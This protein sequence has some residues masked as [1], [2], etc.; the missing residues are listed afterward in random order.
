[1]QQVTIKNEFIS[2]S[3]L[4]YGAII[5]KILFKDREGN[6]LNLAVGF[7]NPENY[8][9]DQISLGACVGRFAGRISNGGFKLKG[10]SYNLYADDGVH[11]HGGKK[12]QGPL[13]KI[14]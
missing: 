11:L 9:E 12:Q 14:S 3:V 2:L 4:D 8:L 5:Q 6:T 1:M 7:E 13:K 10:D